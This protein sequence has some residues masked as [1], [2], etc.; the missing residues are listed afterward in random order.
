M[1]VD[2]GQLVRG[3]LTY[4]VREPALD[5]VRF[6]RIMNGFGQHYL[7]SSR[8]PNRFSFER[9]EGYLR[10]GRFDAFGLVDGGKVERIGQE[11]KVEGN[12]VTFAPR[13]GWLR[14]SLNLRTTFM[15]WA[16]L[17]L[18]SAFAVGGDWLAWLAGVIAVWTVTILLVQV[19]LR[20]KVRR[21]L[22]RES[23]N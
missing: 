12:V 10:V 20:S 13:F 22:A 4:T 23:W 17:F 15:I 21:W 3:M 11:Q 19:S 18:F 14:Y 8:S 16:I 9:T 5:D 2:L 1:A 7:I 6:E